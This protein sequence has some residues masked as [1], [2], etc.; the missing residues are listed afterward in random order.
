MTTNKQDHAQPRTT[1]ENLMESAYINA[2][3]TEG[4][5]QFNIELMRAET[6]HQLTLTL[7]VDHRLF[8]I[9]DDY[10]TTQ[11]INSSM[12]ELFSRANDLQSIVFDSL[13]SRVRAQ[14]LYCE[15][16]VI[17]R[18]GDNY[19]SREMCRDTF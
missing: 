1:A 14:N 5:E 3:M 16:T 18:S 7:N 2:L 17:F 11:D 19:S 9:S 13:F 8:S 15:L 4:H 6:S 10:G 12:P